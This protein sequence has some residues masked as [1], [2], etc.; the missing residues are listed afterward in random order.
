[1]KKQF[2]PIINT[3]YTIMEVSESIMDLCYLLC[4]FQLISSVSSAE[5]ST[6][7]S[8]NHLSIYFPCFLFLPFSHSL[9][10]SACCC[11]AISKSRKIKS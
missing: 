8:S 11:D 10:R 7:L 6:F 5:I 2:A 4:L 3:L 9:S 1:M